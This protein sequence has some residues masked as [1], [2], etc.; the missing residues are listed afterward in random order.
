MAKWNGDGMTK[1]IVIQEL[2][3]LDMLWQKI[4][5]SAERSKLALRK[6]CDL[7]DAITF[8]SELKFTKIGCDPLD[9]QRALNFI[10]QVNQTFTY[11]ASIK[12]AQE[13]MR[14]YPNTHI[15]MNLGT[16]SGSDIEA[17]D[18]SFVCEVFSA[19][20]TKNNRKL[21]KDIEKVKLSACKDKY[22]FYLVPH[23][24]PREYERDG[25]NIV[26]LGL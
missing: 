7:K 14:R 26:S 18:G 15:R 25:I 23:E 22:I 24:D 4:N 13:L 16:A 12:A 21:E 1:S 9:G 19:V 3:D 20:N 2:S 10:E 5:E 17:T 8:L 6:L 11:Y